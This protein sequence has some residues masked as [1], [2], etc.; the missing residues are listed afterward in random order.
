M[1]GPIRYRIVG[2]IFVLA[3]IN[4]VDRANIAIAAPVMIRELGWMRPRPGRFPNQVDG[5]PL[6]NG[7]NPTSF[8]SSWLVHTIPMIL[9]GPPG[10]VAN[11]TVYSALVRSPRTF[12]TA[13]APSM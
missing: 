6:R 13:P 8:G 9:P 4:H 2:L 10:F 5:A 12:P 1:L 7:E 11:A 3:L